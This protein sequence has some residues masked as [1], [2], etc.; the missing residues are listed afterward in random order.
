MST[1]NEMQALVVQ[2]YG[3]PSIVVKYTTFPVPSLT[4]SS[5]LI[6]VHAS[7]VNPVDWKRIKGWVKLIMNTK[8]PF[9][10]G[11]DFAGVVVAVAENIKEWKVG[12]EVYGK[13]SE[14]A[15][16]CH[17]EYALIDTTTSWVAKK[18]THL[19][20]PAAGSIGL[21]A[22]T[23]YEGLI[24]HG[25]ISL[26][27]SDN[28]SS[29]ILVIGASGGIGTLVGQI[30][31]S[32]GIGEI[33]GVCS[34]SNENLIK[35]HGYNF[36][37]DYTKGNLTQQFRDQNKQ[38]YF[39]LILDLVGGDE[40]YTQLAALVLKPSKPFVTAV[41]PYPYGDKITVG[42]LLGFGTTIMKHKM[43][44]KNPYRMIMS[45]TNKG[46]EFLEEK[47]KN[48]EILPVVQEC[49]PLSDGVKAYEISMGKRVK[50][51]VVI[52]PSN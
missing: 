50:G 17:G 29:K 24:T 19:P 18:P 41:G 28:S 11:L 6:K 2:E 47:V 52:V 22:I 16:G 35:Q 4:P 42:A 32:L 9:I 8:L 25:D 33:W 30:A 51:K 15:L 3:D 31:K 44:G 7:S 12:D 39:D 21:A 5:L 13:V 14:T 37:I 34:G 48:G 49:V 43:F 10:F 1:P 38:N 36:F 26:N 27:S 40:Y 46:Y 23:A 20:W 45:L